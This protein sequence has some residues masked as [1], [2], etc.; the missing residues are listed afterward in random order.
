M[1]CEAK[2]KRALEQTPG[3]LEAK[4][5]RAKKRAEAKYDPDR[6]SA[7][8]LVEVIAKTGFKPVL[9]Q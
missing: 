3:V 2:V 6:V 9:K 7:D 4:A 8:R 5:D 1:L